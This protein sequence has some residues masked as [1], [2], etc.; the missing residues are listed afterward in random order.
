MSQLANYIRENGGDR[1]FHM[2]RMVTTVK[3]VEF[4]TPVY[5]YD[6]LVEALDKSGIESDDLSRI[7][8]R[9]GGLADWETF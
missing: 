2:F 1:G 6:E 5:T 8:A 4:G 7:M 3:G 9:R